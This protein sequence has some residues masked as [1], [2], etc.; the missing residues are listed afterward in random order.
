MRNRSLVEEEGEGGE[1][2]EKEGQGGVGG[3]KRGRRSEVKKK[4]EEE[5]GRRGK[6]DS[7]KRGAVVFVGTGNRPSYVH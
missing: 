1:A 7:Q 5:R 3:E 6:S 4:K 2:K